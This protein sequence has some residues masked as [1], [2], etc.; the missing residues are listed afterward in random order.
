MAVLENHHAASAF[1]VLMEDQYNF[2]ASFDKNEFKIF[3][4]IFTQCILATD[5]SQ[6]FSNLSKFKS[7]VSSEE[8]DPKK[9]QGDKEMVL[10]FSVHMS[11][12][13]NPCKPFA[14]CR[15]WTELL[16]NGEFFVQGDHERTAGDP[17]SYLMDR[18]TVNMAKAQ[19]GFI[20]VIVIPGFEVLSL[21]LPELKIMIEG[22]RN[23]KDTWISLQD[24]FEELMKAEK[25]KLPRKSLPGDGSII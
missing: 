8:F 9:N 25:K 20:D 14:L 6:H 21:V 4:K 17:I 19:L 12:I 13:S 18:S 3:R 22:A 2:L 5:M 24:E 1:Q 7:R 10:C 23:N 11:D 16:Y 15:K